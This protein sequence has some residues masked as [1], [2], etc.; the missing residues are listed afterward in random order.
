MVDDG[1]AMISFFGASPLQDNFTTIFF[2]GSR[3][4]KIR[5]IL[6][7]VP[8]SISGVDLAKIPR[9]LQG[10]QKKLCTFIIALRFF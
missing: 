3:P 9:F 2:S 6:Q 8:K 7:G 4:C 1:M 10:R 5:G